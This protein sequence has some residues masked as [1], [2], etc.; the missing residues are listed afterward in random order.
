MPVTLKEVAREAGVS[1]S[2]AC[3]ALNNSAGIH[4]DTRKRVAN[5]AARLNYRTN[6]VARGLVT[7][8]SH[9]IGLVISDIRN[10]F[11][12]EVARGAEDAA[13]RAGRD[14]VLCNSDLDA[15]KQMRY[16]EWLLAKRID[17]I[18]MNSV[19]PLSPAQQDQLCAAGVPVVLLNLSLAR[20]RS[21]VRRFSAAI[22]DNLA[23]GEI[24]GNYLI[25]LGHTNVLHITGPRTHGNFADRAIG[26]LKVFHDRGLPK[27]V[28]AFGEHTL[29]A[30]CQAA[31]QHL[32]AER[33][34]TAVFAGNDVIAFGCMR[35]MMEQGIRI[36]Q[37]VSIIG[38]DNVEMS[39][40]TC[41]P[42]TTIDQPKYET[43]K[44]AVEM[45][46]SM[47]AKGGVH[48]PEHR[49]IGVRLVERQSC[50]RISSTVA[51]D[52]KPARVNAPGD[53][54]RPCS[55]KNEGARKEQ[56]NHSGDG[57]VRRGTAMSRT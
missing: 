21:P 35:A 12:A 15:A 13:F 17:G 26:F 41:P 19:A 23:G 25:D 20:R 52:R 42:L 33:K 56:Q 31:R 8:Q 51:S 16:L 4:A 46:L 30:A 40:I 11:F 53:S 48:D 5:V 50:Q 43:G 44:A 47:I 2:T 54:S 37:D 14:L 55:A 49:I 10:P 32:A 29:G 57:R 27:P 7:G 24:A 18:V 45:L 38:F 39:Q 1:I 28:V 3:R 6:Q 34:V 36:P 22:A 9:S